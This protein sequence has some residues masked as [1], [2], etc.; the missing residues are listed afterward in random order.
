MYQILLCFALLAS[1]IATEAAIYY[2]E[3]AARFSVIVGFPLNIDYA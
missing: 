1:S 2:V 3:Q